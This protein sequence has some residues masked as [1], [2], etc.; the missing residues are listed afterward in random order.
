VLRA[1]QLT[2]LVATSAATLHAEPGEDAVR[3]QY[4][5]PS[6]CPDAAGF[7]AEV[8]A[9]TARG[10]FAEPSELARTFDVRLVAD[11]QGFSGD[12]EFL[13]DGG[14]RV[15]R[16]VHGEQCGAVV[17]T[18]A[19]I[20]ALALDATAP[21][22]AS[23]PIAAAPKPADTSP[24]VPAATPAR[25]VQ[26]HVS[27]SGVTRHSLRGARL[28]VLSGYGSA[29]GAPEVALLGQLDFSAWS[30]RLTAH[31][32]WH[33][34]VVGAGRSANLRLQGLEISVCP[35]RFRRGTLGVTPCAALDLGWLRAAGVASG[36]LTS[37][38]D[39]GIGWAALGPQLGLSWEPDAPFWVE[40]RVQA[41]FP[42]RWGYQFTFDRPHQTAYEVPYIAGSVAV[43]SG[44]RF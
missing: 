1:W 26:T 9:R 19:L 13:D 41:E 34:R 15:S 2:L 7:A 42:L 43:V 12:V 37:T 22:A 35:W 25:P 20:T 36:Q 29:I 16:H 33:E 5:A 21:A 40:L 28:G 6:A 17:S 18:L 14:V 27:S 11:A 3:L 30:L 32:A 39:E 23:K 38:R 24:P 10:R 8:R 31:Y 4:A 44:V